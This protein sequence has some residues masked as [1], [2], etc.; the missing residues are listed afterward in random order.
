MIAAAVGDEP[1]SSW[2]DRDLL[3]WKSRKA[4]FPVQRLKRTTMKRL[5]CPATVLLLLGCGEK[6]APKPT[7][8]PEPAPPAAAQPKE[9]A[10]ANQATVESKKP[11]TGEN[12]IDEA[13]K[14][15][16]GTWEAQADEVRLM[17]VF[18][19]DRTVSEKADRGTG[20][21][22]VNEGKWK[23]FA[24]DGDTVTLEIQPE[25]K[26]S[27]HQTDIFDG[28]NEL[29]HKHGGKVISFMRK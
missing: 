14:R 8:T 20:W 1:W 13:T 28:A 16:I 29:L 9:A 15:V 24:V 12:S 17:M 21:K 26:P 3:S 11:A 4:T 6:S 22:S 18:G 5:I 25:G 10:A 27:Y 23:V 7:T 19:P 2:P